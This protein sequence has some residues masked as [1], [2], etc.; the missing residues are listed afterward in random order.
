MPAIV[1]RNHRDSAIAKLRLPRQLRLGNIGHPDDLESQLPV[2]MRLC[3]RRKLRA[4]DTHVSTA[5]MD[6]HSAFRTRISK[7]RG[8][9]AAGWLVKRDMRHQ[10]ASEKCRHAILR[11]IHKLISTRKFSRA[12]H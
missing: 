2:N 12:Q 11:A 4:L 10:A 5:R 9:L 3:Q 1:V 8:N 7:D 6:F